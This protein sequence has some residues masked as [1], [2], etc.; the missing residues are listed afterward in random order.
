MTVNVQ[1]P[2]RDEIGIFPVYFGYLQAFEK[3]LVNPNAR[4][5]VSFS[6][7]RSSIASSAGSL[8]KRQES[9]DIGVSVERIGL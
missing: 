1:S 5:T 3:Y 6:G 9:F 4:R 7:K 8:S 2:L